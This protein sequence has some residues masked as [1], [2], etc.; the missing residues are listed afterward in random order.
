MAEQGNDDEMRRVVAA[1]LAHAYQA[2]DN[3]EPMDRIEADLVNRGCSKDLAAAV[4]QRAHEAHRQHA[5]TRGTNQDGP[6]RVP[7]ERS[8]SG[9]MALGAIICLVGII[10][11]AAS[12]S[13]A[14]GGGTYVVAWGAIV[15]GAVR[16]FKGMASD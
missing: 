10:I 5:Q 12:Y 4:I 3:G 7:S 2:I 15:F 1:L 11:T 8:G 14:S 6:F 13:S 9:D 16:F